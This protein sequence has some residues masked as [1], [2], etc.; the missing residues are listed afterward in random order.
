MIRPDLKLIVIDPEVATTPTAEAARRNRGSAEVREE[1]TERWSDGG[2]GV[3]L[4]EG[5][6]TLLIRR[7]RGQAFKACQGSRPDYN[8]CGLYTLADGHGCGMECTYCV[9]QHYLTAPHLTSFANLKDLLAPAAAAASN[10]PDR[11]LRICTGE[12]SDSLL[13][14]PITEVTRHLL[15]LFATL[16]QN[17]VLEL[18]T[19]TDN[20]ENLLERDPVN[21]VLVSWSLNPPEISQREEL[22]TASIP[23]RLAAARRV[24]AHGYPVGFHFDPLIRYPGWRDGYGA[25]LAEMRHAVSPDRVAWISMG[26]LRMSPAMKSTVEDRFPGSNLTAGE[27]LRAPDGKLRYPRPMRLEMFR[28][29]L[30]R[31][32]DLGYDLE[33]DNPP[34]YLCMERLHVWRRLFSNPPTTPQEVDQRLGN[35]FLRRYSGSTES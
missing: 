13:L 14:E 18:K 24:A 7:F 23:R 17:T 22:R 29:V 10:Q 34:V 21:R 9:L 26:S 1:P 8:C 35:A 20:V 16:P 6:R 33:G 5:K 31:L 27:L 12:L 2:R 25:L 11:L 4:S 30:D 28:F 19:K 3:S 15:P 32:E